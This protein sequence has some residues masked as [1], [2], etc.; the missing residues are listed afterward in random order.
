VAPVISHRGLRHELHGEDNKNK[1]HLPRR[2][3]EEPAAAKILFSGP[4]PTLNVAHR[5]V[6]WLN[7]IQ[8]EKGS[9]Q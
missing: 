5:F 4:D 1:K 9:L 7:N 3:R 6:I 2:L 8:F